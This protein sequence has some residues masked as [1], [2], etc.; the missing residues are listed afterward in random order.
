MQVSNTLSYYVMATVTAV[1]VFIV[2]ASDLNYW[3]R[4]EVADIDKHASLFYSSN[5]FDMFYNTC[6]G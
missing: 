1:M 4:V 2:Q 6:P 3:T 5:T